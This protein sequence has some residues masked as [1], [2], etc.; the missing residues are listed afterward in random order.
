MG[1]KTVYT[2]LAYALKNMFSIKR[3]FPDA[4]SCPGLQQFQAYARP[5][6]HKSSNSISKKCKIVDTVLRWMRAL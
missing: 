1:L 2:F 5:V 4:R 3:K 6:V